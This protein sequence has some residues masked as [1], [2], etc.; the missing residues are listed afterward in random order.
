[1][2]HYENAPRSP[3]P[4]LISDDPD[5]ID[6]N[7][8]C[9]VVSALDK[10]ISAPPSNLLP[11]V[12]KQQSAAAQG[13][14]DQLDYRN[15]YDAPPPLSVSDSTSDLPPSHSRLSHS[16]LFTDSSARSSLHSSSSDVLARP[17]HPNARI[18]KL[19]IPNRHVSQSRSQRSGASSGTQ[20]CVVYDFDLTL[21]TTHMWDQLTTQEQR[22][23]TREWNFSKRLLRNSFGGDDR[24]KLLHDH[25]HWLRLRDIPCFIV[26]HSWT[27]LI[28]YALR[29]LDLLEYFTEIF[30]REVSLSYHK[31]SELIKG[32]ILEPME[33]RVIFVDDSPKN[34]DDVKSARAASRLVQVEN[35][36]N[37]ENIHEIEDIISN[38]ISRSRRSAS[39]IGV[40]KGD[41]TQTPGFESNQPRTS[42]PKSGKFDASKFHPPYRIAHEDEARSSSAVSVPSSRSK[43]SESPKHKNAEEQEL[44]R[45]SSSRSDSAPRIKELEGS[46]TSDY[47]EY[48]R[49]S[50]FKNSGKFAPPRKPNN[51]TRNDYYESDVRNSPPRDSG[52]LEPYDTAGYYEQERG[53]S[54]PKSGKFQVPPPPR[55]GDMYRTKQY[56]EPRRES[57]PMSGRF[58][59]ANY[60]INREEVR[61]TEYSLRP[62]WNSA[63][64]SPEVRDTSYSHRLYSSS[65]SRSSLQMDPFAKTRKPE[66]SL[67]DTQYSEHANYSYSPVRPTRSRGRGYR[68]R[69]R[70]SRGRGGYHERISRSPPQTISKVPSKAF[71]SNQDDSIP[72][73]W[74]TP[75]FDEDDYG[76]SIPAKNRDASPEKRNHFPRYVQKKFT[77]SPQKQPSRPSPPRKKKKLL[78]SPE[79]SQVKKE[80]FS[81][82]KQKYPELKRYSPRKNRRIPYPIESKSKFKKKDYRKVMARA[83]EQPPKKKK[84]IISP[85]AVPRPLSKPV[86]I[87]QPK[88]QRKKQQPV[89]VIGKKGLPKSKPSRPEVPNPVNDDDDESSSCE[90][91]PFAIP[92][93][94]RVKNAKLEE[95]IP[96]IFMER[97]VT[98]LHLKKL[99]RDLN[100][101]GLKLP[102]PVHNFKD[103]TLM[104]YFTF[105]PKSNKVKFIGWKCSNVDC[106]WLNR[107]HRAICINCGTGC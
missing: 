95:E 33:L 13:S 25:L 64:S 63:S 98:V 56:D 59:V 86:P 84:E 82:R 30:G 60:A 50:G 21:T 14:D 28:K 43:R 20:Y 41:P 51:K 15:P 1:M 102:N 99:R 92:A 73:S 4:T 24:I 97:N 96:S 37:K 65:S 80:N 52:P 101:V 17:F 5:L 93:M 46:E 10:E 58:E 54:P 18:P 53:P 47:S 23:D 100:E 74:S 70:G 85:K 31:R 83:F 39:K 66:R 94:M 78:T 71:P 6:V 77:D 104:E 55:K 49:Q 105:D 72:D 12:N 76:G 79:E 35:G 107:S 38:I 8:L 75:R 81:P 36:M 2:N 9:Q 32:K 91:E 26:S 57:P 22:Q 106:G 34:H 42:V 27:S 16:S 90:V 19:N 48:M 68:Q 11:E 45:S 69:G 103:A 40:F 44:N 61:D 62:G 67:R 3:S 87:I 89:N 7:A 29:S 88:V